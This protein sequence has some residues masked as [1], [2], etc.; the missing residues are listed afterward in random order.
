MAVDAL[1]SALDGVKK[2]P[3]GG[4]VARCPHHEDKSP[5]LAIKEAPDGRVLVHCFAGC[6]P[7]S[8]VES[9]GL[10]L[11]DLFPDR[12]PDSGPVRRP[13]NPYEVLRLISKEAL[14]VAIAGK[15]VAKGAAL[16]EAES[17]RVLQSAGRIEAAMELALEVKHKWRQ[18][19]RVKTKAT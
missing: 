6:P 5:S 7:L 19:G 15:R 10:S 16:S 9:V 12:L 17:N 11:S 4:W 3:D 1:L 8:I 14:I 18:A 2:R 13:F